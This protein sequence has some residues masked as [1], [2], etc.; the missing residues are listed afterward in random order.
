MMEG[1]RRTCEDIKSGE[2]V[3]MS[4]YVSCSIHILLNLKFRALLRKSSKQ[5]ESEEVRY[6]II[7]FF[8]HFAACDC[9][10]VGSGGH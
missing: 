1:K 5:Y 8:Q 7:I 9:I 4:M 3:C 2:Y 10:D 6:P